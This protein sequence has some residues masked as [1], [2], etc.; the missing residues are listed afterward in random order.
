LF[1]PPL[2]ALVLLLLVVLG[3]GLVVVL[4]VLLLLPPQL[5]FHENGHWTGSNV[6]TSIVLVLLP[7]HIL[8]FVNLQPYFAIPLKILP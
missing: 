7:L 8:C 5:T 1:I 2:L 3:L 6:G 4:L